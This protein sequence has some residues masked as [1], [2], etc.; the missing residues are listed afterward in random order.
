M[1]SLIEAAKKDVVIDDNWDLLKFLRHARNLTSGHITFYTLPIDHYAAR[2]GQSV[3]IINESLG[4]RP[5]PA[6]GAVGCPGR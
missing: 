3:N 6:H 2:N 5:H 1:Q 4:L